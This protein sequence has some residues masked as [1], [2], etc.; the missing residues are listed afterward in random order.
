M[1]NTNK[2]SGE[3]CFLQKGTSCDGPEQWPSFTP[4]PDYKPRGQTINILGEQYQLIITDEKEDPRLANV[5][6]F[7]DNTAKKCVVDDC[8]NR[9]DL[10][11]KENLKL[12]M[13]E[14][15][16]H[17]IIHAFLCESGLAD[18]CE[19]A[20]NETIVDW[21]AMQGLKIYKAW[22]QAGAVDI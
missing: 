14:T 4:N 11:D 21:F 1:E 19:W 5:C 6:G 20:A 18:I 9:N 8:S 3:R 17:E 13:Q 10:M 22:E 12:Q 16:R 15:I 7:C 2:C